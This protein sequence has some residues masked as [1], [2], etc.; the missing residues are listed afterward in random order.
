[1]RPGDW[2]VITGT[3]AD[4]LTSDTFK[5]IASAELASK[6]DLTPNTKPGYYRLALPGVARPVVRAL[7]AIAAGRVDSKDAITAESLA[8]AITQR[9]STR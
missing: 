9:I 5:E 7:A 6:I 1:M 8:G 4:L 3:E 2:I